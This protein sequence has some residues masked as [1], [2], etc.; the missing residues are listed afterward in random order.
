MICLEMLEQEEEEVAD[1]HGYN[2]SMTIN[3]IL[4]I[5]LLGKLELFIVTFFGS[6]CSSLWLLVEVA[7]IKKLVHAAEYL[8]LEFSLLEDLLILYQKVK[9]GRPLS[10]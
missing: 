7:V 3:L 2:D 4:I 6:S 5:F 8:R 10:V 9:A 1:Y